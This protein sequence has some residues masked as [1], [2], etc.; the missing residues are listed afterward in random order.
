MNS[1]T[2]SVDISN[3]NFL[4]KVVDIVHAISEKV[5][6]NWGLLVVVVLGSRSRSQEEG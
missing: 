1:F 4:N 5:D 2:G 3:C 6:T